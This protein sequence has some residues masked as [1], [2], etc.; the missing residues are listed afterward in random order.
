MINTGI[1]LLSISYVV[2]CVWMV[3]SSLPW[4]KLVSSSSFSIYNAISLGCCSLMQPEL[5][6]RKLFT[7]SPRWGVSC[8]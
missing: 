1:F 2:L 7:K 4:V 3:E 5:N 8:R 6:A